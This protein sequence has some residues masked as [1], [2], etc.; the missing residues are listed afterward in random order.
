[1]IMDMRISLATDNIGSNVSGESVTNT[2]FAA[3]VFVSIMTAAA[4]FIILNSWNPVGWVA[5]AGSI[6]VGIIGSFFT[7]LFTSKT[8][9][10][11]RL[12]KI[13]VSNYVIVLI[14][15]LIRI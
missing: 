13:C 1:M 9:K 8:E 10:S 15:V 3:G 11:E 14:L 4:P 7:S 12:Q 5:A 2:R 6:I